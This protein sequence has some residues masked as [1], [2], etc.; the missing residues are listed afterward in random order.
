MASPRPSDCNWTLSYAYTDAELTRFT[1]IDPF[2]FQ[3]L[4]DHSGNTP[5]YTPE[6][7]ANIWVSQRFANGFGI[8]GGARYVSEQFIDED[9]AF[10]IDAYLTLDALLTFEK[11][12]WGA[13]VHLR[14]LTDEEYEGR[15]FGGAS[16]LPADGFNVMGGVHFDL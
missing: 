2:F 1:E 10:E 11:E 13:R 3:V 15:G 16:V 6:H 8:S 14:N 4:L 5:A 7:L 9:N 12:R